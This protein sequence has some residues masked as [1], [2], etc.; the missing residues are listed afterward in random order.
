LP[1]IERITLFDE[2]FS[3]IKYIWLN[4]QKGNSTKLIS[5][6]VFPALKNYHFW[7]FWKILERIVKI[8]DMLEKISDQIRNQRVKIYKKYLV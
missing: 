3:K 4:Y 5:K 2:Q 1:I 7:P 8:L 6:L